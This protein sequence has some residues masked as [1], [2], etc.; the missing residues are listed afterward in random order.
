MVD[1]KNDETDMTSLAALRTNLASLRRARGA[2]RSATA[3]SA[4][5]TAI[6]LALA[7]VFLL[8]WGFSLPL[9]QR[10]VVIALGIAGVVWAY[11][12]FTE[13]NLGVQEDDVDMAL[14][15]ERQLNIDSDLVAAL[16]FE[17]PRAVNWGSPQLEAAVVKYVSDAAPGLN[18]FEGF[19]RDQMIRRGVALGVTAL[20]VLGFAIAAPGY[21]S[22]FLQRLAFGSVH[23]P[24][25]TQLVEIAVNDAFVATGVGRPLLDAKCPQGQ[26][27]AFL[28]QA[29]NLI[30]DE[31]RVRIS[32]VSGTSLKT[33][34]PLRK[35]SLEERRKRLE[36]AATMIQGAIDEPQTDIT[37]PW[38]ERLT[39]LV[40]FDA[41]AIDQQ[42]HAFVGQRD[43]L[44]KL[45]QQLN[46]R[47]A[48]WPKGVERTALYVGELGRL[49]D[50][51]HYELRLGDAF[52]D[53]ARID[54]IPLPTVELKLAATP[55]AYARASADHVDLSARQIS[56]LEGTRVDVAI[57]ATNKKPLREAWLTVAAKDGAQR[58]DLAQQASDPSRWALQ[59]ADS[60]FQRLS[61]EL[62]YEIQVTDEDGLHLEMPLRGVIRLRPDRPPTASAE[63]VH[64]V[65]LPTAEP[66]V[67][68]RATD[69]YGIGAIRLAV[70]VQRKASESDRSAEPDN[71][72]GVKEPGTDAGLA[73][74]GALVPAEKKTFNIPPPTGAYPIQAGLP[75]TDGRFAVPLAALNLAKGDA[76]KLTVEVVD[77]RGEA[78]GV[79][80]FSE[81]LMLEISDE[82]GVLAAISEADQRSEERLNDIIKRELGIGES[83]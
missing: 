15:V 63:V 53:L 38:A 7:G 78:A 71:P 12:R 13:P 18:V 73:G 34:V 77:D 58:Y 56:L 19:N 74:E 60:P 22:A 16:Q 20:V 75:I 39:A 17:D 49:V 9:A 6:L 61:E 5:G 37:G 21:V 24:T 50:S 40:R 45:A 2:V 47:L 54:M 72:F 23:Y 44:P 3:W 43:A 83:P 67:R 10:L 11:R 70:E 1:A 64:R 36:Q 35:L 41:P 81:P 31:G 59:A 27:V 29:A 66:V 76:V 65:I 55:P 28:V 51:V 4:L 14:M 32:S 68:F 79:A 52:T 46:D 30:P 8:D 33:E 25:R 62:K 26:P 48:A 42:H 57:E 69:D 80:A 82:S